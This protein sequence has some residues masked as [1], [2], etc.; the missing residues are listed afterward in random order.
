[1]GTLVSVIIPVYN[2]EIY[3]RDC[4]DS[5]L[6]QCTSEVDIILVNDGST[7]KSGSICKEFAKRFPETIKTLDQKNSGSF[8]SRMNG[9]R[10][11]SSE[12]IMF[13]DSDDFLLDNAL[14]VILSM[15]HMEKCDMYIFNATS[16]LKNKKP[17]FCIPFSN[18]QQ[19]SG[20]DKYQ[21]Y[22][23]LCC[24]D[25]LNNL[26][27]KCI[28]RELLL[29]TDLPNSEQRLTMG[30]D[31]YQILEITEKAKTIMY[32]D[33]VLYFYRVLENSISRVYNPYYYSSVKTVCEKRIE[34]AKKWSRN[35][36]LVSGALIETYKIL[37]ETARKIF[38]SNMPWGAA[39]EEM[40]RLREDLFFL[41]YYMNS[42]AAPDRR[43]IV[44]KAPLPLFHLAR[45]LMGKGKTK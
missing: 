37:R 6:S 8:R 20:E 16:D 3:L 43:D 40:Q 2:A 9:I 38:V 19:F 31:L 13:M 28:R 22:Q 35:D 7:D 34:C 27:T 45:I 1:M 32:L 30:E 12:Y 42:H 44:L 17:L 41:K 33:E 26:W 15:L 14:K 24:S 29:Q 4:L 18:R 5:L 10:I 23:L 36:E 39:K 11:S 25:S 21:V